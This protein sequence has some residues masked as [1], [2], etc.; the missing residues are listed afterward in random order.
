MKK[1][2]PIYSILNN[3]IFLL[4]D[5]WRTYPL[6]VFYLVLQIIFSVISPVLTMLLP[7]ITLDLVLAKAEAGRIRSSRLFSATEQVQSWPGLQRPCLKKKQK[8]ERENKAVF[9]L[10]AQ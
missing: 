4:K 1:E 7:K 8:P 3:I 5:M 9:S 2:K 10:Y 6:L